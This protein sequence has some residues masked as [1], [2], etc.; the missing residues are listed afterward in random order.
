MNRIHFHLVGQADLYAVVRGLS[1]I[2]FDRF[3]LHCFLIEVHPCLKY[4]E[5][6]DISEIATPSS[7]GLYSFQSAKLKEKDRFLKS[8]FSERL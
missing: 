8:Q 3:V 4:V 2:R 5:L 6:S 1:A 7:L